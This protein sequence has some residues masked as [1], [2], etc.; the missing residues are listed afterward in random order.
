[1]PARKL[2]HGMSVRSTSGRRGGILKWLGAALS[3]AI[4]GLLMSRIDS[5]RLGEALTQVNLASLVPAVA[6]FLVAGWIRSVRWRLLL[7]DGAASTAVLFRALMV[8]FSVNNLLPAR[9]GEIARAYLLKRWRNVALAVT[10]ASLVAERI[11]DGLALVGLL[12]LALVMLP[13]APN[14]LW[15]L[16]CVVGAAFGGVA[17]L[18]AIV[19]W[20]P[21]V[22]DCVSRYLG[23]RLAPR[24]NARLIGIAAD[25]NVGFRPLR[26]RPRLVVVLGL[27]LAGWAAELGV[28]YI[29]M[30]GFRMPGSLALAFASGAAANFATLVPS[31]PG[32]VGTFDG[33]L[34]KV[35][36]DSATISTELAAAYAIVVHAVLFVPVIVL[37]SVILW[38]ANVSVGEIARQRRPPETLV[39]VPATLSE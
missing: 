24:I 39:S 10:A 16:G 30:T 21:T 6:L 22:L 20:R 2:R 15:A 3:L 8:G 5:R 28:Y 23:R 14:Y 31:S 36:G 35:L 1:M 29:V 32:Y 19:V 25:L 34:V 26:R 11:L 4:V 9:L 12:L 38:R 27:S 17:L 33:V 7:P 13:S 37:G 18:I